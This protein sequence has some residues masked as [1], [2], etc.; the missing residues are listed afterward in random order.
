[1][2]VENTLP[3]IQSPNPTEEYLKELRNNNIKIPNL[4]QHVR[5]A[6][7][8]INTDNFLSLDFSKVRFSDVGQCNEILKKQINRT[9]SLLADP[10]MKRLRLKVFSVGV[11][12]TFVCT[13]I[14]GFSGAIAGAALDVLMCKKPEG[15]RSWPNMIWG[16]IGGSAIGLTTGICLSKKKMD[17][18]IKKDRTY[19]NFKDNLTAAQYKLFVCAINT[20]GE[21]VA[22]EELPVGS[23]YFNA[24]GSYDLIEIPVMSPNG[25]IYDY[26]SIVGYIDYH[27]KELD[28][29]LKT[30]PRATPEQIAKKNRMLDPFDG[31]NFSKEDLM[32]PRDFIRTA[33]A[34]FGR[35]LQKIEVD[36]DVDPLITHGLN[37]IINDYRARHKEINDLVCNTVFLEL[38]NACPNSPNQ[39]DAFMTKFNKFYTLPS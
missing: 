20:Y 29:F 18:A 2:H 30:F 3:F 19:K 23:E 12:T 36:P 5:L 7:T 15:P 35:I 31:P 25:T 9:Y 26:D 6:P 28:K 14:G 32:Y 34:H 22:N 13:A 4:P 37:C 10:S 39:V 38:Q 27:E 11:K 21:Q 17:V 33:L 16:S 24:L 8:Q 1:M